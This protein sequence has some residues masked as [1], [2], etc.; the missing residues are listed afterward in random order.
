MAKYVFIYTG[1]ATP[2]TEAEFAA[3]IKAWTDWYTV[4]GSAVL[5]PGNPFT[6][7][8]KHVSS[9][10]EISPGMVESWTSGYTIIDAESIE[11]A[12]KIGQSCPVLDG[13]GEIYIYEAMNVM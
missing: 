8:A 6:P 7:G 10:G 12:A 3:I 11:A 2:E 1:G 5:D 9:S 13:G 4:L